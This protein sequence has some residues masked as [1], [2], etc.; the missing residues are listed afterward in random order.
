M[1]PRAGAGGPAARTRT[2]IYKEE[3]KH[4][5]LFFLSEFRVNQSEADG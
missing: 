5:F 4:T 3:G 2:K 1:R